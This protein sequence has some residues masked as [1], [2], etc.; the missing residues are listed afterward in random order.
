M[1]RHYARIVTS[2]WEDDE[3]SALSIGAQRTYLMLI[4][5]PD[6]TACG[7]LAVTVRRWARRMP[8]KDQPQLL[9]WLRELASAKFIVMDED[10]EELLIRTFVKWDGGANNN[11]R[12]KAIESASI[13]VRSP[14][15]R[16]AMAVELGKVGLKPAFPVPDPVTAG[17][18][19]IEALS[20]R[21]S[22]STSDTRRVVVKTVGS[23]TSTREPQPG[24]REP[25]PA[26]NAPSPQAASE[27]DRFPEF[28]SIYPRKVKKP[29]AQKAYAAAR[30]KAPQHV[31]LAGAQCY[32]DDPHLPETRFIPH[33]STWLN[34]ECWNDP[35]C[36]PREE[37]TRSKPNAATERNNESRAV[38]ARLEAMEANGYN[39][40]LALGAAQ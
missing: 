38:I 32:A 28:W 15:L 31:L 10:T 29:Q 6:V 3:F 35:P 25:Q 9:P 22:D 18:G 33:P 39:P 12:V 23:S 40:M 36:P 5:Q 30:K 34:G 20:D 13:G 1:A 2:I 8:P 19:P 17:E 16:R 7:S 14:I 21:A 4:S 24:N 37:P 26:A 27:P 11:L